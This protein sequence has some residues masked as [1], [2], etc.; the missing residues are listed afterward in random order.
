MLLMCYIYIF[1]FKQKTAYEMRISDWSSDVCSSDLV[2]DVLQLEHL[3]IGHVRLGQQ[4]VHMAW[5]AARDRMDRIFDVDAFLLEQV[6]HSAQRVL[7]LRDS[8]AVTGVDDAILRLAHQDGGVVGAA[9]LRT[10]QSRVGRGGGR[11]GQSRGP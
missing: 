11:T 4:D 3:V 7:R 10:E 5:H 2:V 8:H 1:F 6:G 9:G